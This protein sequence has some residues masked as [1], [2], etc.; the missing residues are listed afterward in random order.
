MSVNW[1]QFLAAVLTAWLL[2]IGIDFLFHASLLKYVW[3]QEFAAVK[4]LE[5][6]ALLIPVGY[7]SFL[8]L[9]AL[10]GYLFVSIFKEKPLLKDA[11]KF[12][13]VFSALFSLSSF[14]GQFSFLNLPTVFL[15][16]T[17]I[18]SFVEVFSV[19]ILFHG[20]LFAKGIKKKALLVIVAF[21]LLLMAGIIIQNI[22]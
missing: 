18:I 17:S 8:L 6:L 14:L 4:P 7:L 11:V 15:A 1:K 3:G 13:L 20:L 9:T 22:F 10:I 2:F 16:I 19:T 12:A 21:V 5:E